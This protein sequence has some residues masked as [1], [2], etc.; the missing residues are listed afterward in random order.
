MIA[1]LPKLW[2]GGTCYILGGGPSL[3]KVNLDLLKGKRVIGV[4]NAYLLAP[5]IDAIYFM[6]CAWYNQHQAKLLDFKG[7]KVTVCEKCKNVPGI[8]CFK[9]GK[10][11]GIEDKV[12]C[13][14]TGSNGG[15]GAINL[16]IKL[17]VK[18]IVLLGYDM[19]VID[20]HHNYHTDHTRKIPEAIYETQFIKNFRSLVEPCKE[21]GIQIV[22]CTPGSA[23]DAFPLEPLEDHL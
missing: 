7:I 10:R 21:R 23:L 8:F 13:I 16:A 11:N 12:D 14:G 4:N 1:K 18:K 2:Y 19:R 17:G 9:R 6:D 5:W 3:A 20:G 22:N 15:F